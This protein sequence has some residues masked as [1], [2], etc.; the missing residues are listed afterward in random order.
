[1]SS[2]RLTCVLLLLCACEPPSATTDGGRDPDTDGGTDET[3]R[4]AGECVPTT[5]E[6]RGLACG[7]IDDG[8]GSSL[9]CGSCDEGDVC[10][11]GACTGCTPTSCEALGRSCGTASDGCGRTLTCGDDCPALASDVCEI[12]EA[13]GVTTLAQYDFVWTIEGTGHTAGAYVTG[14]CW[15]VGPVT[16]RSVSPAPYGESNG[17]MANPEAGP[18][19]GQ[20][21]EGGA[22]SYR[23][24][25]ALSF[26][27]EAAPNTSIVSSRTD[28][29]FAGTT[30]HQGWVLA[31]AVLTVVEDA[32]GPG[33]F[34]PPYAGDDKSLRFTIDDLDLSFLPSVAAAGDAPSLA[35]MV[36][37]TERPWIDHLFEYN[38]RTMHAIENM[39]GYGANITATVGAACLTSTI[40]H[41]LEER[42]PLIVNLVQLGIDDY[43][44]IEAGQYYPANGGHHSGRL[45][46]ILYA[47]RALD[48]EGMLEVSSRTFPIPEG[49]AENCQT[50][51]DGSYGIRY[52]SRGDTS[53]SYMSV[54]APT[55]VGESLCARMIGV[56]E[57]WG[58]PP[59]F[60]FVASWVPD[61]PGDTYDGLDRFSAGMWAEYDASY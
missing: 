27:Y 8:C 56:E 34:R 60:A 38:G 40:D 12:A 20:A 5:C 24:S 25:L 55:W 22:S 47:G 6:A 14:D 58:H 54:N 9:E 7:E 44:L 49:F 16:V 37:R 32:A 43:G 13:D 51:G 48:H 21:Y 19:T 61:H 1:M 31:H 33:Y 30:S 46:P 3:P 23:A 52:C 10:V 39:P 18:G 36:G 17:S 50:Y 28:P 26:P 2:T 29:E 42:M 53:Q 45:L 41:P 35:S 4:D 11:E 15:I 57:A 59:F